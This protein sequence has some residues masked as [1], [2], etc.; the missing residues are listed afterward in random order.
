MASVTITIQA[1]SDSYMTEDNLVLGTALGEGDLR[2]VY[3]L[4]NI[5]SRGIIGTSRPPVIEWITDPRW[6]EIQIPGHQGQ[7]HLSR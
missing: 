3:G 6:D 4:P 5:T 1:A 7:S 2:K